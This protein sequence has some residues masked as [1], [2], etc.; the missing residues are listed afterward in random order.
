MSPSAIWCYPGETV[1]RMADV[2][3]INK[4]D[5]AAPA[6]VRIAEDALRAINPAGGAGRL[7][8]RARRCRRRA[9]QAAI[10]RARACAAAG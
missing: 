3:V 6:D 2:L 4:V 10:A 7:A 9:G 5:T 1:A 8:D